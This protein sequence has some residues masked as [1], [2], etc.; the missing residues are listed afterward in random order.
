[1][2]GFGKWFPRKGPADS[3]LH[4]MF[5]PWR[6]RAQLEQWGERRATVMEVALRK[7]EPV[8]NLHAV[9]NL[10]V[11]VNFF[12]FIITEKGRDRERKWDGVRVMKDKE[13]NLEEV[14]VP[15]TLGGGSYIILSLYIS[16]VKEVVNRQRSRKPLGGRVVKPY[17]WMISRLFYKTSWGLCTVL[18]S[19]SLERDRL[20]QVYT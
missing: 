2:Y 13:L 17:F 20:I 5:H 19:D 8:P 14:K 15:H 11:S 12:L 10:H 4:V 9:P 1:M 16:S 3:S 7:L 18:V 6:G